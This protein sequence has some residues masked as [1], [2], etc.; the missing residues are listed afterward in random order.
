MLKHL[1]IENYALI[2]QSD[3]HFDSGF[4]AITG[5]TGA[6]KSI[7]LDAIGLLLG[8]RA[9][10]QVLQDKN[11]KCI[12]EATWEVSRLALQPLFEQYDLDYDDTLLLRRELS[13]AGKSR[14]FINDSP[15][16]LST[17]R[18]IGSRL[19]D[20]HSQHQTLTLAGSRFQ[21]DLLDTWAAAEGDNILTQY[22]EAYSEYL[23]L[24]QLLEELTT[25]ETQYRKE[26]DYNRYLFDELEAAAL[27]DN[28]Q[29]QLEE[30]QQLMANT[31]EIKNALAQ[32][33]ALLE[34]DNHDAPAALPTLATAKG[35][36]GHIAHYSK[37]IETLHL[38]LESSIIELR[39]IAGEL[40]S[41]D[42]RFQF[43]PQRQTEINER[44]DL[45]Y[46]LQKKHG[47][48]SIAQLLAIQEE[49]D[50]KL[51]NMAT[52]DDR[53]QHTMEAVDKSYSRVQQLAGC[54]TA[55][56]QQAAQH[57]EEA[58]PPLLTALGMK[59]AR[60]TVRITAAPAYGPRGGDMVQFLFNAN[61]GGEPRNLAKVASGGEMSRLMLA[62]KSLG[63]QQRLLPTV[64][65]DEIDSG[66]SG[67]IAG[68][69]SLIMQQMA[70]HIQ[71]IAITHLPQIAAGASQHLW[72][73]KAV[74]DDS[75]R[76][77]SHIRTLSP[78]EHLHEIAVM[79]SAEP[80]TAAALQT[81]REL[82]AHHA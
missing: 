11:A 10:T 71:V 47:V 57:L 27:Q 19:I 58:L 72:V 73:H 29:A 79:L 44:L 52:L 4:V 2:A 61:R 74:N 68:R 40:Q 70:Q 24:K 9:D 63:V 5:E 30:E 67:D 62:I 39:D 80:P 34:G 78:D 15:V 43:S 3:I 50:N 76:T 26:Q 64:V 60:L 49:L 65:F 20:I 55:R 17:L 66:V 13:P 7:M 28:E 82:I 37:E 69:V 12:V 38:R 42:D 53:I 54:L 75:D 8:D 18:D 1:H 32:S 33:S 35:L 22:A 23:Q 81:A 45:I 48:D 25:Q 21:L 6:G 36:L 14:A 46:K 31:E 41:L 51:Q 16:P 77:I 56:R 59:E